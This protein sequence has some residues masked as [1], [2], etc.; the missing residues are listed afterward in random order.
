ML[1]AL[2]GILGASCAPAETSILEVIQALETAVN[3]TDLEGMMALYASDAIVEES[4]RDMIFDGAEEIE[5]LWRSYFSAPHPS[6]FREIS[7]D[8]NSATFIW[9]EIGAMNNVLWPVVIE[10]RNGKITYM[11]FYENSSLEFAGDS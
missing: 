10:A 11:D 7:I 8:G 4:F 3:E 1:A 5:L 9:A 2:V 6:E